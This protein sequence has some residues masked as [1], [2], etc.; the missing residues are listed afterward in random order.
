MNETPVS[1]QEFKE[2]ALEELEE[3]KKLIST[4]DEMAFKQIRNDE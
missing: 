1:K 4:D 3:L 2:W